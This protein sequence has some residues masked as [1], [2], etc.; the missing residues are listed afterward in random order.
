MPLLADAIANS[1]GCDA[2]TEKIQWLEPFTD[3]I[4]YSEFCE[5]TDP[6]GH[7]ESNSS[8]GHKE[9]QDRLRCIALREEGK[10]KAEIAATLGRSAKFVATWWRKEQKEVPRP[11]GVHEYLKTEFWRDIQIVR[12]FGR[13]YHVYEDALSSTEWIDNMADGQGFKD[14][15]SRLKYDK[16]GRMRPNGSQYSKDGLLPGRL[17]KLD[18]L[19]QRLLSE[20]GIDDRVLKRPGMLWYPDGSAAAIPH[21][22]EAWTAL[23]S[24]GSPRI[25]TIDNHPVLLRDGD[26]IVFGTQRHGVPKM[27]NEGQSF[28]DYGGRM[29]I[30]FFFMPTGK[31]AAGAEPWKAILDEGPSRKLV[32][33][34]KDAD[35]GGSAELHALRSG[36][37][38][39]ALA[40][41]V[42]IGFQEAEAATA[43]RLAS[44]DIERAAELLLRGECSGESGAFGSLET[45]TGR[46]AQRNSLY[47]RLA[48]LQ[49]DRHL[50]CHT[51]GVD[52]ETLAL[53]LHF[54]DQG[55][56]E[57]CQGDSSWWEERA[58]LEQLQELERADSTVLESVDGSA[59]LSAQFQRYDEMLDR[60]DAEIW[61]GRGD[62]MVRPW[63]REHLQIEQQESCTIYSLGLG[64]HLKERD[65][66]ELLSLNSVRVLYDLRAHAERSKNFQSPESLEKCCKAR[67]I[68]YRHIALG[69]E[70]AFGIL[71]HLREDEGKNTL[72]ELVWHARRKRA[73]F[74]GSEENWRDDHR[75]AIAA[76]L[77]QAGHRVLHILSSGETEE[78]PREL[79]LPDH[80]VGEEARLRLLE[81][82]KLAG[83]MEK[84]HK[85]AASRGTEVIA[86]RLSQTRQEIDVGAELRKATTQRELCNIQRR[87][88][89]LQRRS[90]T[91]DAK[92]GLGPKLLHVNK[93]VKAEAARQQ[94]NLDAG[95]T[96]DGKERPT[97]AQTTFGGVSATQGCASSSFSLVPSGGAAA[98]AAP[99]Q[100]PGADVLEADFESYSTPAVDHVLVE[101][102]SCDRPTMS[103]LQEVDGVGNG[104]AALA[105]NSTQAQ[106]VRNVIPASDSCLQG[107]RGPQD[108]DAKPALNDVS[109]RRSAWRSKRG[110]R[111]AHDI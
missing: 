97:A 12:G 42:A 65:F 85:S 107:V 74:L 92:A 11:A 64:P 63:R 37:H 111:S 17:P 9:Y 45:A 93:W 101:R 10:E 28:E 88:A 86:Q 60:E 30:V 15:G 104:G 19:V 13:G 100:V 35:L 82:K 67:G 52:D 83:D 110:Q 16:E 57:C 32:A 73:T 39:E 72:A 108:C 80:V 2:P 68:H 25:L 44:F 98:S 20:Q 95:K 31:Q 94:V 58:I 36:Q 26:L 102:L 43:L 7:L 87:L 24:F 55:S 21:R 71:K 89:D 38:G 84:P 54:Q 105:P 41:L 77:Q 53:S 78:Q 106:D 47:A 22:H 48:A 8:G 34:K 1:V 27:C 56:L 90:E 59:S 99:A 69:R 23:M 96:K 6:A 50:D 51:S 76:R 5:S 33:M 61:D 46:E 40:G 109:Q 18:K 62:L 81:K 14:G 66:F 29:S 3:K 79:E 103:E 70:S 91:S 75:C 4:R 49:Q